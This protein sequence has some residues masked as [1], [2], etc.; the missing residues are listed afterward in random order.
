MDTIT[1]AFHEMIKNMWKC[2]KIYNEQGINSAIH[3]LSQID[4]NIK[5]LIDHL[6]SFE[7]GDN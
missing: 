4:E 5:T 2:M 1:T 7:E 3:A 6:K